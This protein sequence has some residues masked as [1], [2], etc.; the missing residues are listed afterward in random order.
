MPYVDIVNGRTYPAD[1]PRWQSDDGN[2]VDLAPGP[3]MTRDRIDPSIRSIWRYAHAMQ[4]SALDA[5]TLGEGW[6]PL[7]SKPWSGMTVQ[8]KLEYV[9]PTGSFKDRGMT[10]MV[11]YLK[12]HG[13][14]EVLEDSS[15]NAGAS[16]ATYAAAAGMRCRIMVPASASYPKIAQMAAHG[17]DVVAVSGTRQD[18]A[19]AALRES[20]AMF[21]ASHNRQPFFLEGT[22]TL[23]YELWE[24]LGFR[25]PDNVIV[26]VGYGANVLG[27]ER[28]F[29]E[30]IR[31]GEIERMPR[32]FGVQAA[33]VSPLAQAFDEGLEDFKEIMPQPTL[34]EGIASQRPT[35]GRA[36]LRA[37]RE[38]HG[39]ILSVSEDEI[40]SAL[41][42]LAAMG[43][44]VEPTCASAGAALARLIEAREIAPRE[45]TVVVLTGTGLK[46][47][48]SIGK[49]L[50]L[51]AR[52]APR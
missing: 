51:A 7:L 50:G 15:G 18:V 8:W 42:T 17:A 21:Y 27:C 46:A 4:V 37:V 26:P 19:D 1:V 22:K 3:G 36:I 2:G 23:A 38:S 34:A 10:A 20:G 52:T 12:Q 9:M 45:T 25:A 13:I 47:S 28:G 32:I 14:T 33:N 35:R 44:Y 5:V 40:V 16:L 31:A 43:F 39:R 41:R 11:T 24:Q 6:T 49:A 29:A 30:L 48:E